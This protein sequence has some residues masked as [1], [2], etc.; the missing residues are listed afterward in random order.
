MSHPYFA[1]PT[2]IVI[3]HRGAAG[4]QPE[5]TLPSFA[6]ARDL[7]A[8]I[9]ETDAR[10]TRDGSVVLFHDETL[11]RTT[12]GTGRVSD[13]TLAE[14]R[15]LDAGFRFVLEQ[16][17]RFPFRGQGI[18]VPTLEE[19]LEA[20]PGVRVNIE[21]KEDGPGFIDRVLG[22]LREAGREEMTLLTAGEDPLMESLRREVRRAR[23][24]V[25]LG[26]STGD[27]LRFVRAALQGTT[28][29][30]GVMALQVPAGFGGRPLVTPRLVEHAHAHDVHVHV[31]TINEPGE[32][33]RLLDL[34]VDGIISDY[35]GRLAAVVAQ[36]RAG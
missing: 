20:I 2:P 32:M 18:V 28:P 21:L 8:A 34:G 3:G 30:P 25:A 29:D 16:G 1:L 22:I 33:H 13:R 19:T 35:P 11:E 17:N 23:S 31:W 4:E 5:N 15:A 12:N 9:L 10:P 24:R 6:R 14:L 27:V 7:C 36:R 26:A